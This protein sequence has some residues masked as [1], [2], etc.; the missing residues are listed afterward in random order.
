MMSNSFKTRPIR[1]ASGFLADV[2]STEDTALQM[3]KMSKLCSFG[4]ALNG[5]ETHASVFVGCGVGASAAHV[6]LNAFV[7][8]GAW[9]ALIA[10]LR[11]AA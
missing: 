6:K 4:L 8:D 9:R 3:N 1:A 5:R 7:I 10:G 2:L 11:I